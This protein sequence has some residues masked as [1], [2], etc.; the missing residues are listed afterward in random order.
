MMKINRLDVKF[1]NRE[2]GIISSTAEGTLCTFEYNK[3]WLANGFC[4]SPLELPL[5]PDVFIAEPK[6]F[7][8]GFGIFEDSLPD[9][10][11]RYLLHKAMQQ[12]GLKYN[13]LS[14]LQKLSLVG[15]RGM[16]GL[17]YFPET[18]TLPADANTD[19]DYLQ[20][21][22]LEVLSEQQA[23]DINMLLFNSNN[24]GGARPKTIMKDDEGHWLVK[25]RHTYDPA[26]IGIQEYNYNRIARQCGISVPDFKL[27]N[28]KYFASRRFD[29]DKNGMR[30]HMATAGALLRI[31]LG[32]PILDYSNLLALTGFVT[33]NTQDVEEMFRRMIFNYLTDNK[34]D[35][36]KNFSFIV[37]RDTARNWKWRL[38]PAYDLTLCEEGYNGEHATSVCGK[39]NPSLSDFIEVGQK[40][41]IAKTKCLAIIEEV[42]TNCRDIRQYNLKK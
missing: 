40:I 2:V 8:G 26:N 34:D 9:G 13:D 11:G 42:Y 20:Q 19:L 33:Q 3:Q 24:S 15:S 16:G 18:S 7:R 29:I 41:R 39:A 28:N 37:D 5:K 17:E 31:P 21:K 35:H 14:I 38:A 30:L 25:F 36:C 12:Q 6:P 4:L 32:N 22:A 10:Y 23:D 27:V 1:R